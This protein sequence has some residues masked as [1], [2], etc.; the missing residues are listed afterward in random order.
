VSSGNE[1]KGFLSQLFSPSRPHPITYTLYVCFHLSNNAWTHSGLDS[2]W[3][4]LVS[5]KFL[6][7]RCS[8]TLHDAHHRFSGLHTGKN[9]AEM[10]W[11]WDWA[12][13]TLTKTENLARHQKQ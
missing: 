12:F 9:Y 13:G 5:L 4:N 2:W 8:N 3:I 11:L 1:R 7:L 10:F 6:P